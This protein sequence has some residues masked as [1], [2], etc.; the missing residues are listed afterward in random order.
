M[1]TAFLT[2]VA[3]SL[4]APAGAELRPATAASEAAEVAFLDGWREADGTRIGALAIRL[5]PGWHT[6]WRAPGEAGIPPR[7]DWTGSGN[8]ASVEFVWPAPRLL[9]AAGLSYLGYDADLI[10]PVRLVPVDPS[11]PVEVSLTVDF[12]VCADICVPTIGHVS[13]V[14]GGRPGEGIDSAEIR[15]ALARRARAP[16]EAGVT[17]V[18]CAIAP[19]GNVLNLTARL[20]FRA[21]PPDA[22][23]VVVETPSDDV[24]IPHAAP[25]RDGRVVA[26]ATRVENFGTGPLMLDRSALRVTVIGRDGAIE[27]EG[28]PA[29]RT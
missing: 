8:I 18:S 11:R 6:Y 15:S 29:P 21:A 3:L 23:V 2:L 13:A 20:E 7:F 4:A 16:A 24:W 9:E 27:V 17:S 1:K 12:G 19:A 22:G 26:A 28:C 10:L 5:A 14:L 25:V